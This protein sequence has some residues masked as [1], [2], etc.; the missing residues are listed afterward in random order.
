MHVGLRITYNCLQHYLLIRFSVRQVSQEIHMIY[1][2]NPRL[3]IS[4]LQTTQADSIYAY[5]RRWK[6]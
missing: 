3:Q 2:I 6:L 1:S 4:W 5:Q